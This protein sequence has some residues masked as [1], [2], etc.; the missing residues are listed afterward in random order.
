MS[1]FTVKNFCKAAMAVAI[2]DLAIGGSMGELS[3]LEAGLDVGII[4]SAL[5]AHESV[6]AQPAPAPVKT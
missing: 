4:G 1:I 5:L 3:P 2:G 6:E